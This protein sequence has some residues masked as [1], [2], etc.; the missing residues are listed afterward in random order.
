MKIAVV[1][2]C[3]LLYLLLFPVYIALISSIIES[4]GISCHQFTDDTQLYI[5]TDASNYELSLKP[6]RCC[7]T[8]VS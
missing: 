6:H 3:H 5:S 2:V 7:K 1:Y 4:F 8:V